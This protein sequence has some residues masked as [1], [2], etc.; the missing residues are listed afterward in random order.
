MKGKRNCK[1]ARGHDAVG[2]DRCPG[3]RRLFWEGR[4]PSREPWKG[5][6]LGVGF[7]QSTFLTDG[8]VARH[9]SRARWKRE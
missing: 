8:S 5:V 7:H 6:E 9:V 3:P 2:G 4:R 1:K